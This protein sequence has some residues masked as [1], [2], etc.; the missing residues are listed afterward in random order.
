MIKVQSLKKAVTNEHVSL[1]LGQARPV[2]SADGEHFAA[3]Q[4]KTR[5]RS[6]RRSAERTACATRGGP[7]TSEHDGVDCHE[8]EALILNV[9]FGAGEMNDVL[10]PAS[11]H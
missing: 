4:G 6:E 2:R 8:G 10:A 3:P 11:I 7:E 5:A 9:L 1:G